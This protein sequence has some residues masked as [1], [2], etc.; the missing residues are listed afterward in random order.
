MDGL[1][2]RS[3]FYVFLV[4]IA[5]EF[6]RRRDDLFHPQ[7]SAEDGTRFYAQAY[8][9]G[10][11]RALPLPNVGYLDLAPRLVAS[12]GLLVPL[13][14]APLLMN[15]CG[16]AMQALPA[17]YLVSRRCR[18]WGPLNLRMALAGLYMVMPNSAPL[19]IVPTNSPWHLAIVALL[20]AFAT[21][22]DTW[23][24]RTTDIALILLAAL[25]GPYSILMVPVVLVY[26]AVSRRRWNWVVAAV[27]SLS[28]TV[29]VWY[30]LHT[31]R[32]V[33]P[34]LGASL[35]SLLRMLGGDIFLNSLVG[36]NPYPARLPMPLIVIA[37]A[38]GLLILWAGNRAAP[39]PVRLFTVFAFLLFAASIYRPLTLDSHPV[40]P[41]LVG[42]HGQRYF[43]IPIVACTWS[44]LWA[45]C[46]ASERS[47]RK[48]AIICVCILPVGI[49]MDLFRPRSHDYQFPAHARE[50]EE[51][52]PGQVTRFEIDP[53]GWQM[54]LIKH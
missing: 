1:A 13:R 47:L 43:Y 10:W 52:A 35:S 20:I 9:L 12:L 54:E 49:G 30:L 2:R 36:S 51:A 31:P 41:Q 17:V 14:W 4:A 37:V 53:G 5:I 34:V 46:H 27:V 40:W 33:T 18:T 22:P 25:S 26:A 29:Q 50:F 15:F 38:F 3:V 45:A 42:A 44:L 32:G 16:A 48:L 19:H 7:F 23:V 28:A 8:N 24:Q 11:L 21:A 6:L 39:L